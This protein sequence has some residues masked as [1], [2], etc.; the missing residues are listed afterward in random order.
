MT[1]EISCDK[2]FAVGL[3]NW[4]I[5]IYNELTCHHQG[6]GEELGC[7]IELEETWTK[8]GGPGS[9]EGHACVVLEESVGGEVPSSRS[10]ILDDRS[11]PSER[12]YW[13]GWGKMMSSERLDAEARSRESRRSARS[14]TVWWG[15]FMPCCRLLSV[16]FHSGGTILQKRELKEGLG[17][18]DFS[19]ASLQDR[20]REN[21]WC[22]SR[23]FRLVLLEIVLRSPVLI[24]YAPNHARIRKILAF[25]CQIWY[26]ECKIRHGSDLLKQ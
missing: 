12:V 21:I 25:R 17:K 24:E 1:A 15:D 3:S 8:R 11:G 2:C 13:G 18:T 16:T 20:V 23:V 10:M 6:A 14:C 22:V 4:E 26:C 9:E 7:D 19:T 5:I